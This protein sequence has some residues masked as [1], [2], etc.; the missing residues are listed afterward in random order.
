MLH[1]FVVYFVA[2]INVQVMVSSSE[3]SVSLKLNEAMTVEAAKFRIGKK[4]G[5]LPYQQKLL[6]TGKKLRDRLTLSHYNK[7]AEWPN[8]QLIESML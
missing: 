4:L 5:I 2:T 6:C 1:T 7:L 8:L 3:V